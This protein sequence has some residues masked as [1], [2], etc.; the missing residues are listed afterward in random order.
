MQ[1]IIQKHEEVVQHANS[2]YELLAS[3]KKMMGEQISRLL[4]EQ[5]IRKKEEESNI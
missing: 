5:A 2:D 4:D 3:E 1:Q